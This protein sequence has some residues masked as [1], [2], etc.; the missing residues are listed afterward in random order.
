ML[1]KIG[2]RHDVLCE[3]FT[4]EL[5]ELVRNR[6]IEEGKNRKVNKLNYDIPICGIILNSVK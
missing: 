5:N 6:R 4:S 3:V 2:E 1:C